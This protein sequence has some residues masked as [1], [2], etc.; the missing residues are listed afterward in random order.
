MGKK[1]WVKKNGSKKMGKKKWV[2][3]MGQKN[4]SKKW[5]KKNGPKNWSKKL[6]QK[7][8]RY[9]NCIGTKVTQKLKNSKKA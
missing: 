5:V 6:V 3:K 9:K 7:L 4:G 8:Y 1:K 2:K